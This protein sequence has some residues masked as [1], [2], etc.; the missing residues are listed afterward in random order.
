L[1]WCLPLNLLNLTYRKKHRPIYPTVFPGGGNPIQKLKKIIKRLL[2]FHKYPPE[3][4]D[5]AM[6]IVMR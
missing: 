2:K 1:L 6:K 4:A 3:Q 5:Q